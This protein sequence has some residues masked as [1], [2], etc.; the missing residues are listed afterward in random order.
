M[1]IR[2]L[3]RQLSEV[4][5]SF[6]DA[7]AC[8]LVRKALVEAAFDHCIEWFGEPVDVAGPCQTL[9]GFLCRLPMEPGPSKICDHID[10]RRIWRR[11]IGTCLNLLRLVRKRWIL[12]LP[13][14]K[15]AVGPTCADPSTRMPDRKRLT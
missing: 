12:A 9:E 2:S 4:L 7:Y 13:C 5:D 1:N 3:V 14:N 10:E 15:R 8:D 11:E 6:R